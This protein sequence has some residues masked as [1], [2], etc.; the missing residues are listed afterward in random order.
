MGTTRPNSKLDI[1]TSVCNEKL[2]D[3]PTLLAIA[4]QGA[5]EMAALVSF[6]NDLAHARWWI[7]PDLSKGY[8]KM[9]PDAPAVEIE[10]I[11]IN[12]DKLAIITNRFVHVLWEAWKISY[13]DKKLETSKLWREIAL[14]DLNTPGPSPPNTK[15]RKRKNTEHSK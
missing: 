15:D 13:P 1:Y 7:P 3:H 12:T 4:I 8:R 10:N 6:R 14:T 9:S 5:K 11:D 2:T